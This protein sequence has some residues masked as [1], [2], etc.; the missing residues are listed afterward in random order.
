[1]SQESL[2]E[3]LIRRRWYNPF[4]K[5]RYTERPDIAAANV[6]EGNIV[7]LVDN[8]PS[9]MVLPS[10]IFDFIQEADDFYYPP[11]I[12]GYLRLIRNVIFSLH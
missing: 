4:P 9:A 10:S 11:I 7:I 1:M 8:D 12:G 2:A 6:L 3:C 5:I